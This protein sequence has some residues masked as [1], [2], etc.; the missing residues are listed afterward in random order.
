MAEVSLKVD[1]VDAFQYKIQKINN[2]LEPDQL[3]SYYIYISILIN[4]YILIKSKANK[5]ILLGIKI[6]KTTIINN[7]Y[8]K[9]KFKI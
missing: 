4:K 5:C 2:L 3:W 7:P 9:F 1:S 8:F 6:F